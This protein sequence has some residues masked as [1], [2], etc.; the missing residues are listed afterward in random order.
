MA[1]ELLFGTVTKKYFPISILENQKRFT[2]LDIE[3]QRQG[4][5]LAIQYEDNRKKYGHTTW[6]DWC[7][8][9]WGTKWNAYSCQKVSDTIYTFE[10]AWAGV[11]NLI[12]KMSQQFPNVKILYK[13]SDE[14][15]GSNCGIGEYQNGEVFFNQ[16]ENG[17]D[18]AYELA[19]ELRPEYKENFKKVDGVYKYVE[20]EEE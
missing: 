16:L 14:D 7:V 8:E 6:Y 9:N 10:T 19:F 15:T 11:P 18:E 13:Y 3:Q 17:S 2:K 5:A 12:E 20:E 4:I 1:H